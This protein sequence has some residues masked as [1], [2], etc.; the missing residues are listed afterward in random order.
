VLSEIEVRL[1]PETPKNVFKN[2]K[3]SFSLLTVFD[4]EVDIK[5]PVGVSFFE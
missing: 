5:L 1:F 4:V 3:S 2:P